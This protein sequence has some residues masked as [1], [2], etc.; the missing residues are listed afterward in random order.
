MGSLPTDSFSFRGNLQQGGEWAC[1]NPPPTNLSFSSTKTNNRGESEQVSPPPAKFSD[2]SS[3]SLSQPFVDLSPADNQ[4]RLMTNTTGHGNSDDF[5]L[6]PSRRTSYPASLSGPADYHP[7]DS[8][9]VQRRGR[10]H[11]P[12]GDDSTLRDLDQE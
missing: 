5:L 11:S 7:D 4:S 1:I 6:Y 8:H 10:S 9:E 3:T 12:L 2:T